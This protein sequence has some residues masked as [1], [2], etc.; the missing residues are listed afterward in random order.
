LGIY[1]R[2]K[3][4]ESFEAMLRR[5]NRMIISGRILSTAK[6]K[7]FHQKPPN[8]K[9]RRKAALRRKAVLHQRRKEMF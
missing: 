8:R 4:R 9:K 6:E 1:V 5:F 2:R 3:E 7:R